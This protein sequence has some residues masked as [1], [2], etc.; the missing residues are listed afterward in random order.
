MDDL[1]FGGWRIDDWELEAIKNQGLFETWRLIGM[2]GGFPRSVVIRIDCIICGDW[3][4][5]IWVG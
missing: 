2:G 5:F 1:C 4:M 3:R